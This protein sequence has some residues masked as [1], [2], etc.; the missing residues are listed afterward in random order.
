[1]HFSSDADIRHN[2]TWL[3]THGFCLI[4]KRVTQCDLVCRLH[5][6]NR[7]GSGRIIVLSTRPLAARARTVDHLAECWKWENARRNKDSVLCLLSKAHFKDYWFFA[8]LAFTIESGQSDFP[9]CYKESLVPVVII[10]ICILRFPQ[11]FTY[12]FLLCILDTESCVS[13]VLTA[14]TPTSIVIVHPYSTLFGHDHLE[15]RISYSLSPNKVP[16]AGVD[17]ER[18]R[19]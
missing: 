5:N 10:C 17:R 7:G 13:F 16:S 11:L 2:G 12:P 19:K 9:R 15:L 8:L 3:P 6:I 18:M 4:V 14:E 1:M